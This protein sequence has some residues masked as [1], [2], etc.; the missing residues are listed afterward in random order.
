MP[1]KLKSDAQ[2]FLH[3]ESVRL[4]LRVRVEMNLGNAIT[5]QKLNLSHFRSCNDNEKVSGKWL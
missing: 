5:P 3:G 4:T 1:G 2:N